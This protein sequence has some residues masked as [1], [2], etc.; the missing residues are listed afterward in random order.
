M[1]EKLQE[2]KQPQLYNQDIISKIG[3]VTLDLKHYPGEDFYCDGEIEDELLAIARD[4]PE[5]EFPRI[6]EEKGSWP[7]LYH[8]SP[9]RENIVE[10]LPISKEMKVLEIGAGCGAITGALARKAQEVSCVDLSKKRSTINAY[11]HRDCGN[12]TIHVGNFQDIEPEL[13]CD[14]DYICLIGVF[15]YGQSYIRSETPYEDFLR[16]IRRHLAPGGHI[17]IAIENKFGLKYWAG[18]REDHVGTYFGGLEDYPDGG[19][20]RTFT[21]DGLR[22]IADHCGVKELWMYYPYPD[23]KFPTAVYSD[24]RLPIKG[25]LCCN[26]RNFD[27]DRLLLFDEKRVFDSIIKEGQFPLFSNSYMMIL[28]PKL[29]ESYVKYSND[30][31]DAF[32]IRTVLRQK[33]DG[34]GRKIEKHPLSKMADAHIRG[35]YHAWEKLQ[36]RYEGSALAVNQCALLENEDGFSA[37]ELEYIEGVTLSEIVEELLLQGRE[38]ELAELFRVYLD[39]ISFGEEQ[40]VTDYDLIFSN[41]LIEMPQGAEAAILDVGEL[42]KRKWTVIDYEWTFNQ[43]VDSREIAYR[44]LYCYQLE[45]TEITAKEL[46]CCSSQLGLS[47]EDMER[48]RRQERAFQEYVTG[49]RKSMA[50]IREMIGNPVYT[51]E[52]FSSAQQKEASGK[53]RIQLYM[54]TGNGY[55]EEQSVFADAE[56]R[57]TLNVQESGEI[58]LQIP[59]PSKCRAIRLDPCSDFCIVHLKELCWNEK[60][61]ALKKRRLQTNG[62]RIAGSTYAFLTQDPNFSIPLPENGRGAQQEGSLQLVMEITRLPEATVWDLLGKKREKRG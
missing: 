27:R 9:L 46:Y 45:H 26:L 59:V 61:L 37:A 40:G 31:A 52:A 6:I 62:V 43:K 4:Y 18:C 25:E 7:V 49:K 10:W 55:H 38:E 30:R 33:T 17:V 51:L 22:R 16:I 34:S 20:A 12:V 13:P 8:L 28:G 56:G 24:E 19:A 50:Q 36:K 14:Y 23:Y 58:R 48:C 44:A 41:I 39:K 5:S 57:I 42:A 35:I 2:R 15:E 32:Q 47:V 53:G 60:E 1:Q 54:D 3:K 11:R 29:E 21:A